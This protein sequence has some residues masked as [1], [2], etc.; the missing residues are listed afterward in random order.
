MIS[1][2]QAPSLQAPLSAPAFAE[3]TSLQQELGETFE[4]VI[5]A[6]GSDVWQCI[7]KDGFSTSR[8]Y[9]HYFASLPSNPIMMKFW[10]SKC[11]MKHKVFVWLLIMDRLN[12]RNMLRRRHFVITTSWDCILCRSPP[13]ETLDHLFFDCT[14][15]QGCW[16]DLNITWDLSLPLADRLLHAKDAWPWGLFWEVFTL[17]AWALWKVRNAKLFDDLAPSKAA[18]R[19]ILKTDLELL[20]HRSTRDSFKDHLVQI[21]HLVS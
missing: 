18:W 1:L 15:S 19:A 2:P 16:N 11:V 17:V 5:E 4:S 14:F 20:T 7:W 10:K 12:T 9:K 13:E 8:F 21:L 3:F 6:A